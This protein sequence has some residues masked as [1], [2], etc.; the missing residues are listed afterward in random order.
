V[1]ER[2]CGTAGRFPITLLQL[3]ALTLVAILTCGLLVMTLSMKIDASAGAE[4]ERMVR[5]AFNRERQAL[6]DATTDYG[7]WDDAVDH[8]YGAVDRQ[9]LDSNF[10][11]ANPLY[12]IDRAGTP[13]YGWIPDEGRANRL[14]RDAP[15][16]LRQI[17]PILPLA[18]RQGHYPPTRLVPAMYRGGP[19]LMAVAPILPYTATRPVPSGPLRYIVVVRRIDRA[20]LERWGDAFEIKDLSWAPAGADLRGDLKVDFRDLTGRLL[21]HFIFAPVAPGGKVIRAL[22]PLLLLAAALF[23]ALSVM[24]TRSLI[25]TQRRLDARGAA[26]ER[27]AREIEAA[28]EAAEVA[29]REAVEEAEAARAARA[30]VERLA[31]REIEE[32][33]QH[34]AELKQVA[35]DVADS[36]TRSIG[37]LVEA[38]SAQADNLEASAAGTL[39]ALQLQAGPA[40]RARTRSEASADAI[41]L[42]EANVRELVTAAG[43]IQREAVRTETAMRKTDAGSAEAIAANTTL[44]AQVDSITAASALIGRIAAQT[45][46]LSLNAAIEAAH[47]G[48]AGIGFAVVANEV[49]GLAAQTRA[50][51]RDIDSRIS[52]VEAA[53][54]AIG[55]LVGNVHELL[56]ELSVTITST[57]SVVDQHHRSAEEILRTSYKVG[58][59]AEETRAAVAEITDAFDSLRAHADRTRRI[60]LS[61]REGAEQLNAE[62]G[63]VL[64]RLRAA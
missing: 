45:N 56:G 2:T 8:L 9:W 59:D 55:A 28:R 10:G 25:A 47:A 44:L 41:R 54:R 50:T 33:A 58:S 27:H 38:L 43:S 32:Q 62:F 20:M 52:A 14:D 42:I 11:G 7:R 26:A 1:T 13:I 6:I 30:E 18:I 3:T 48:S 29:R 22:A 23:T 5:G 60:G 34:R 21:G 19:A 15:E 17:L 24:L 36:L 37:S 61:V 4:K 53:A 39:E 16:A 31:R 51:T 12:V 57:S 46:L 64:D 49:K 35:Y 63:Q 40:E